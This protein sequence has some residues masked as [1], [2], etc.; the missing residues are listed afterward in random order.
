[1]F[2]ISA[3]VLYALSSPSLSVRSL[4]GLCGDGVGVGGSCGVGGFGGH[5]I[6]TTL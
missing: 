2:D 4:I 1:M 6:I 5:V 3:S